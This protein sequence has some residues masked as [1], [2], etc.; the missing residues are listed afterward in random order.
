MDFNIKVMY[1]CFLK[2][3]CK[4]NIIEPSEQGQYNDIYMEN[5]TAI[6]CAHLKGIEKC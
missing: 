5:E 3:K 1:Y 4:V 6:W 2:E